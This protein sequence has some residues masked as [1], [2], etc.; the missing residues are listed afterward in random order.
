M[1][2]P[3]SAYPAIGAVTAAIIAGGISFVVTV[4]AKEQ[5]IS[6]FRQA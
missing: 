2:I 5:K 1:D 6:E 4:L 3:A